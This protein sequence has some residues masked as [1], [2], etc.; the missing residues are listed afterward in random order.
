MLDRERRRASLGATVALALLLIG[1]AACG[2][3]AAPGAPTATPSPERSQRTFYLGRIPYLT[4]TEVVRRSDPVLDQLADRLGYDR[5]VMVLAPNYSGVLDLLLDGKVD[6]AWFGTE[7]YLDAHRRNLGVEALVVPSRRGKTWYSGEVIVRADSGILTLKDLEGKKFA[8]VDPQSSSGYAAPKRLLE[9]HQLDVPGSFRTRVPGQPDF[10]SKHDN[11]VHAVYFG[12]FDAG[13]VYAGAVVDT[14]SRDP[15]KQRE[16]VTL[17][18]TGR[19]PNEPIVVRADLDPQRKSRIRDAF[20]ALEL[21]EA[22][23]DLFSG[24]ER[25][26]PF[27]VDLLDEEAAALTPVTSTAAEA[28]S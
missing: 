15:V 19:I 13:A 21:K 12:T 24:V 27:T 7:A 1:V 10:L 14:F 2:T 16:V 22:D 23:R 26:L 3:P 9:R 6:A 4:A 17:A 25:F 8:F 28:G 5:V 18:R 20:L 11:V